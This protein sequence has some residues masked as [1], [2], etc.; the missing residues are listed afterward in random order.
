MK[1]MKLFGMFALTFALVFGAAACKQDAGPS[2]DNVKDVLADGEDLSGT[3]KATDGSYYAK[4]TMN[5]DSLKSVDT[6]ELSKV[7][8][9]LDL[10]AT[11]TFTKA[12]ADAFFGEIAEL[13]EDLD[14]T[15]DEIKE[16]KDRFGSDIDVDY[17]ADVR[18]VINGARDKITFYAAA[19][20]SYTTTVL[21][22]SV[23]YDSDVEFEIVFEKQ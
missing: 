21:G 11:Y 13:A 16:I 6:D 2:G 3:W 4:V 19:S 14:D 20:I 9:E 17:D 18:F 8:E 23:D 5:G 22:Q 15:D 12:E 7:L 1:K 10:E